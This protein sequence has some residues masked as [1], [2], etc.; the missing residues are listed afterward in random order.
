MAIEQIDPNE[1][2]ERMKAEAVYVDVRTE[3]EFEAGHPEN[4]KHVPLHHLDDGQMI[5]NDS[6]AEEFQVAFPKETE[7]IMGCRSGG[8]SQKAAEI[9]VGVGYTNVVN[10][11]G[12]FLGKPGQQG[13]DQLGLPTEDG[14]AD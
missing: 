8:R 2:H 3:E 11:V 5:L 9:L 4:A 6:F 1:A 12:G 14:P 13:W 7:L 10:M